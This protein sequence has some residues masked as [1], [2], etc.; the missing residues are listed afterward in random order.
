MRPE[1]MADFTVVFNWL[2]RQYGI[3]SISELY[4]FPWPITVIALLFYM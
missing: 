4:G 2:P 1:R 3:L